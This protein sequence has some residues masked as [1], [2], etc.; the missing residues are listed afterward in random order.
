[1]EIKTKKNFN[2]ILK[3]LTLE[4]VEEDLREDIPPED[5]ETYKCNCNNKEYKNLISY[6]THIYQKHNGQHHP[7]SSHNI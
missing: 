1:M 4:I 7:G 2:E 5:H 6:K 3:Q